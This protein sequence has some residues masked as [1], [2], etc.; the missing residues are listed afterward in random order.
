MENETNKRAEPTLYTLITGASAGLGRA[1]AVRLSQERRLI[2]HGR[3]P[4]R[5]EETRRLCNAADAHVTWVFDLE[6]VSELAASL[7][8]LLAGSGRAVS[9][10]VHCAGM[11]TV[12][13]MRSLDYRAAQKI[14]NVNFLSAVEITNLLLKKKTNGPHL[15]NILFVSSIWSQFG[16][17]AHSA[18]C[19]SK[20]ALDGL[21][22]A[23][24]VELAPAVRVNSILPGAIETSMA[25]RAFDD[26]VILDRL[27]QDYPMGLG[28]PEDIADSI[29]FI[30]SAKARWLTGQQVVVDGGRTV[31]MSLK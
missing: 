23:L 11:V 5:L 14:M 25:A 29:E 10:F 2:L 30:L 31:N 12:L 27:R 19:A 17:R 26:P 20:A 9:A 4:V 7:G 8:P 13:P 16:A 3:D 21:M 1:I 18:Y 28:R 15:G 22:R 24:A 6:Q